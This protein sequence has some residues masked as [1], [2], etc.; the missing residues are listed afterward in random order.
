MIHEAGKTAKQS[1]SIHLWWK[2]KPAEKPKKETE[3]KF[4]S[5]AELKAIPMEQCDEGVV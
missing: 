3:R 4:H 2:S 5:Q 1:G